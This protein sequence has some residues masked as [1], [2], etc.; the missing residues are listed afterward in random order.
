[1]IDLASAVS[2]RLAEQVGERF[3]FVGTVADLEAALDGLPRSAPAAYVLLL[4][5][6]AGDRDS[7]DV[8]H[9]RIA[10][11]F[12]VV[13]VC[14]NM[15]DATGSAASAELHVLRTQVRAALLG[16][17]PDVANSEACA[18]TSGRLLAFKD[19]LLWWTDEF[20]VNTHYLGA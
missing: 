13:I 8:H 1:M 12:A 9:Q 15:R 10:Q 5:E 4:S 3:A 18:F 7:L 16:W 11:D 2:A 19:Q 17:S 14:S 20:M 6:N